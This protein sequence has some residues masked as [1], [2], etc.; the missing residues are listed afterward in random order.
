MDGEV[1]CDLHGE[2]G[3]QESEEEEPGDGGV[4]FL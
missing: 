2:Q 3:E 1:V 4:P